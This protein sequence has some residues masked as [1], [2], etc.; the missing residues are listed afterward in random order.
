MSGRLHAERNMDRKCPPDVAMRASECPPDVAA[1]R[2]MGA[3]WINV[4]SAVAFKVLPL[5]VA[6]YFNCNH[7]KAVV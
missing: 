6:A 2:A 7:E 3:L 4:L 5:N 1:M